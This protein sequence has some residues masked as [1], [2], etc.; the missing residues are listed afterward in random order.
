M[1]FGIWD[2]EFGKLVCEG[3]GDAPSR[4]PKRYRAL[5]IES[6]DLRTCMR[7]FVTS[8]VSFVYLGWRSRGR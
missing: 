5:N 2:L 1:R 8:R 4:A 7:L 3:W 6:R